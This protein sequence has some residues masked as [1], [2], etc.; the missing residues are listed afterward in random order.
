MENANANVKR[1][2]TMLFKEFNNIVKN[3]ENVAAVFSIFIKRYN[4]GRTR[5]LEFSLN[6]SHLILASF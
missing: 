6:S 2:D 5:D 3:D 4:K 1:S